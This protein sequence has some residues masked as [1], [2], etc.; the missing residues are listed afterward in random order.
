M[1]QAIYSRNTKNKDQGNTSVEWIVL[2]C[3][4]CQAAG[5]EYL[6]AENVCAAWFLF[7]NAARLMDNIEDKD[8][9]DINLPPEISLSAATGLFFTAQYAINR[10]FQH[11]DTKNAANDINKAFISKLLIMCE[12]QHQDIV[13]KSPNLK[14]YWQIAE[15]KS[16]SFFSLATYSGARIA[17]RNR[18]ILKEFEQYGYH[19]GLLIQL[20]DDL[21]DIYKW[22]RSDLTGQH[23]SSCLPF[24]YLIEVLPET[25]K[26]LL[27]EYLVEGMNDHSK[28]TSVIDTLDK[29]GAVLY[30]FSEIERHSSLAI[31]SLEK[32]GARS[33][34]KEKLHQII[35]Q[36]IPPQIIS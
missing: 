30:L 7:H 20:L 28:K 14:Q 11:P 12:G 33:P 19:L 23:L 34:A 3:L 16:A 29:N 22:L 17:T 8:T 31:S 24:I 36:L 4:C 26:K 25:E 18:R 10:L 5:G 15:K 1:R 21:E 2:P 13:Q 6:W 9:P 27:V 35:N 32:T